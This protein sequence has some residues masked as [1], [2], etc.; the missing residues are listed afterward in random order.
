MDRELDDVER[1]FVAQLRT[2]G[3]THV[4]GD[5]DRPALTGRATFADVIQEGTLRERLRALNPGPRWATLT[6]RRAC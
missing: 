4:E 1:P 5:L 2:L 6:R 3:W